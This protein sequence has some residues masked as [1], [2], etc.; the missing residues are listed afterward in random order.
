MGLLAARRRGRCDRP[1]A[2]W[3]N[4]AGVAHRGRYILQYGHIRSTFARMKTTV[5]LDDK[6]LRR[7]MKLTGLKT[8]KETI[9]FALTEAERLAKVKRVFERPFYIY[10]AG[11]VIDP[12][13]DV[14]KARKL[15]KRAHASH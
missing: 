11:H 14:V 4:W 1:H 5:D 9:D 8:R 10:P 13:Y 2:D 3:P 12:S 15:E 7:V 6:K